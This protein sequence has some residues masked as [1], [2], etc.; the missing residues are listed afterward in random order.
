LGEFYPE[1]VWRHCMHFC[2]KVLT[3]VLTSKVKEVA[4]MLKGF[5][6]LEDRAAARQKADQVAGKLR[7]MK[8]A[9]AAALLRRLLREVHRGPT[10]ASKKTG[11]LPSDCPTAPIQFS[12][13]SEAVSS[14]PDCRFSVFSF[15]SV[16]IFLGTGSRY[17]L[18]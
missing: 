10:C 1:A 7:G 14:S 17:M 16:S 9:D 8:L 15:L 6:A 4:A 18:S 5:H 13:S 12:A 11:S 3:A 2:R